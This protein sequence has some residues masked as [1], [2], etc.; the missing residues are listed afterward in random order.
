M[1]KLGIGL[2]A[3]PIKKL[4]TEKLA[5]SIHTAV[6][7]SQL[8]GRAAAFGERIHAEDGIARAVDVI[9]RHA[10]DFNRRLAA[11]P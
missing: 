5:Q 7:D 1:A 11:T 6:H 2:R 9:E 8:R 3:A 10:E 4:T